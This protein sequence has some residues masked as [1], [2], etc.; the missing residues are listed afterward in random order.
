MTA[1]ELLAKRDELHAELTAN[2]TT[3]KRD[4]DWFRDRVNELAWLNRQLTRL[5]GIPS[6]K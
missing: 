4:T 5:G 6:D 1:S 2:L 3:A